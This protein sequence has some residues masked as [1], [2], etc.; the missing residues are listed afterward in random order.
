MEEQNILAG[1]QQLLEQII[2]D[3]KKHSQ[4]SA[5]YEGVTAKIREMTRSIE[6]AE[7]AVTEETECKI[8]ES[9]AAISCGYDK[10]IAIDKDKIKEVSAQRD[11]AKMAGVRERIANETAS[12]RQENDG[13]YAQIKE[14]FRTEQIPKFC[15]SRFYLAIFFTKGIMDVL[16]FL[17]T[18]LVVYAAVTLAVYFIPGFPEWGY[19]AVYFVL[20]VLLFAAY[21]LVNARTL[22]RHV[23]TIDG[24]RRTKVEIHANNKKMK[25]I[26]KNIRHDKNEEMYGLHSYD[27]KI[28][29]LHDEISDIEDQKKEAL[30]QFDNTV[31]KDIIAEIEGRNRDRINAMKAELARDSEVQSELDAVLKEE[32]ITLSSKYE[33]YLGKEYVT[34]DKLNQ[35]LSVMKSGAADTIGQAIAVCNEK[36]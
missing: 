32:V 6:S 17:V 29:S 1:D 14:A 33:A 13:L 22:L 21:K 15:S 36:R 20:T 34:P 11:K 7:R 18:L 3:V 30:L 9:T 28:N 4:N 27:D 5:H 2:A 31:K 35:L 10:S 23:E 24:A 8:K 16:I 19:I 12:I 25:R 26:E